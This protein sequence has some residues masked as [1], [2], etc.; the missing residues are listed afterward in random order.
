MRLSAPRLTLGLT[1]PLLLLACGQSPAPQ[2]SV[3]PG[4]EAALPAGAVAL[5]LDPGVNNLYYEPILAATNGWGPIEIDHSIGERG[6]GDG[7]TL[8]LN[9]K[10]YRRGFGAH[11]YSE[12]RFALRDANNTTCTRFTADIGVDDE[13]GSR[14][15]VVFHVFL[16]GKKVYESGVMTGAS[17]TK[18]IDVPI[19][20]QRELRMV[21]TDAGDGMDFDHADWATPLLY[22]QAGTTPPVQGPAGTVDASFNRID[23]GFTVVDTA[24]Q[25]DGKIIVFGTGLVAGAG[26]DSYIIARYNPGG[27]VDTSFGSGGRFTARIGTGNTAIRV[28]VQADGKIVGLGRSTYPEKF[29]NGVLIC[30]LP[31]GQ[32]DP[33][34]RSGKDGIW[35]TDDLPDA[36]RALVVQP[37]GRIVVAGG[38]GNLPG[39]ESLFVAQFTV[40][41]FLPTGQLDAS[42]GSGGRVVTPFP[43]FPNA[44]AQQ[45]VLQPDGKIV[46]G[47]VAEAYNPGAHRTWQLARYL[48][49]GT[50]D[51]TLDGDGRASVLSDRFQVLRMTDLELQADGKFLAIGGDH[52]G[53]CRLIRVNGDGSLDTSLR[54]IGNPNDAPGVLT[55]SPSIAVQ[56][57]QKVVVGGCDRDPDGIGTGSNAYEKV[58]FRLDAG[59]ALDTTFGKM[60]FTAVEDSRNVLLQP[61][62]KIIAGF[63]PITRLFP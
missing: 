17:A 12:L 27:S 62:G 2:A 5:S 52:R 8:T 48:P 50:L 32:P 47:G 4:Q 21:V 30:L 14:G 35:Q 11:A 13:V 7:N 6:A 42:F 38:T 45:L 39:Q 20:G 58:I 3:P 41:R 18:Q 63:N 54:Q 19:S 15:S 56:A 28:T 49:D 24:V 31:N 26:P 43:G 29:P 51:P 10:T 36:S 9:G 40:V 44:I 1:L 25:P 55:S 60:S 22:C 59:G 23:P 33:T 46:A 34:L 37:D 53:F 16:D 61:D 57:D